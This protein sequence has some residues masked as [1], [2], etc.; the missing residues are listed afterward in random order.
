MVFLYR[1]IVLKED[2]PIA[3]EAVEKVWSPAD[4]WR[5]LIEERL[6]KHK[7]AFELF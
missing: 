6:R 7:I 5:R 1:A 4:A 3:Y 2:P